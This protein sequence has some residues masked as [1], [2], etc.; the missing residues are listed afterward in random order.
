MNFQASGNTRS[1]IAEKPAIR[2]RFS[3][4]ALAFSVGMLKLAMA[5]LNLPP[6]FS[7]YWRA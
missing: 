5:S 2:Q 4:M 7:H 1:N 6:H 3:G